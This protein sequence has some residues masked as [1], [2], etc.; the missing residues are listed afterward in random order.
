MSR[1]RSSGG[2][3]K[4]CGRSGSRSSGTDPVPASGTVLAPYGRQVQLSGATG[5]QEEVDICKF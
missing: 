5:P 4:Q 3:Q 1:L 2:G